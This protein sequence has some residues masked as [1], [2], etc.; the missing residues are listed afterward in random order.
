MTLA[1]MCPEYEK[2]FLTG[3]SVGVEAIEMMVELRGRVKCSMCGDDR[4]LLRHVANFA[5]S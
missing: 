3:V 5:S 4:T 2:S 1:L